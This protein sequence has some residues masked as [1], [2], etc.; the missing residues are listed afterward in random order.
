[1]TTGSLR[2]SWR[3]AVMLAEVLAHISHYYGAGGESGATVHM[4]SSPHDLAA[5]GL[6]VILLWIVVRGAR[7]AGL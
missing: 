4:P 1:M 7:R 6:V 3:L 5:W 2:T